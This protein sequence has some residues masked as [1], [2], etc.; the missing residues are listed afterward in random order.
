MA[1]Y[2]IEINDKALQESISGILNKVLNMELA[3]KTVKWWMKKEDALPEPPK[4][5]P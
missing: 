4:E 1:T 5:E 3:K 2:T